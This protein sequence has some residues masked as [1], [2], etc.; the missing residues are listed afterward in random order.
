MQFCNL[1][2]KRQDAVFP[3]IPMKPFDVECLPWKAIA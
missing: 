3:V 1:H 2:A